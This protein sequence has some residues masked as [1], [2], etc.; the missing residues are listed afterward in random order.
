MS[1][2]VRSNVLGLKLAAVVWRAYLMG[3]LCAV[4]HGTMVIV[5]NNDLSDKTVK[6]YP[7]LTNTAKIR[8]YAA[9]KNNKNSPS[10][11]LKSASQSALKQTLSSRLVV[12]GRLLL[13]VAINSL[14]STARVGSF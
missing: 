14:I 6:K 12:R 1:Q 5:R 8:R 7:K 13:P 11:S 3:S 4:R 2:A 10:H 9:L